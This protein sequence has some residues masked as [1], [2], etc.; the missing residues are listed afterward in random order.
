MDDIIGVSHLLLLASS[1]MLTFV[2]YR[3]PPPCTSVTS[4]VPVMKTSLKAL[5]RTIPC[6]AAVV[7]PDGG[8]LQGGGGPGP[9]QLH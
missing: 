1:F 2:P 5:S 3:W 8:G 7:R 4:A 9:P 6:R